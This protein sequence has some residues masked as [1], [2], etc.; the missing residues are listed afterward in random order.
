[1]NTE[2]NARCGAEGE[3][4]ATGDRGADSR[5]ALGQ[6]PLGVLASPPKEATAL[7][8]AGSAVAL[9]VGWGALGDR[10]SCGARSASL[11]ATS[12]EE[13]RPERLVSQRTCVDERRSAQSARIAIAPGALVFDALHG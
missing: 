1:M 7:L 13:T 3:D 11:A 8:G 6:A 4:E 10:G 12:C 5:R 2:A 9:T